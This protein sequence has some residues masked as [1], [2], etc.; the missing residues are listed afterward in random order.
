MDLEDLLVAARSGAA[1][2]ED[3]LFDAI[4]RLLLGHLARHGVGGDVAEDL[5]QETIIRVFEKLD[6]F[7]P[8]HPGAFR[9]WILEIARRVAANRRRRDDTNKTRCADLGNDPS[10]APTELS[11]PSKLYVAQ[12]LSL[13]D[14]KKAELKG[15]L[16]NALDHRLA[17]RSAREAAK[18]EGIGERALR[19]R[20][21]KAIA[22]LRKKIA[23]EWPSPIDTPTN[24]D[25]PT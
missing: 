14:R 9:K 16:R 3:R 22:V 13:V 2:E 4:R 23:R 18:L 21:A 17:G 25:T 8:T 20:S 15:P 19:Q 5:T 6:R 1:R 11:P 24:E 12:K 10:M 7:E